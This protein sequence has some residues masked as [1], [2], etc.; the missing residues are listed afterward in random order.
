[1]GLLM[2]EGGD[3][4]LSSQAVQEFSHFSVQ[5]LTLRAVCPW[6]HA[7]MVARRDPDPRSVCVTVCPCEPASLRRRPSVTPSRRLG[8][9]PSVPASVRLSPPRVV[10]V[11]ASVCRPVRVAS[12]HPVEWP[13]RAVLS[14]PDRAVVSSPNRAVLSS[15]NRA[16]L[17]SPNRAV[18]SYP[19]RAKSCAMPAGLQS[20]ALGSFIFALRASCSMRS[21]CCSASC[22]ISRISWRIFLRV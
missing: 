16:V 19:N 2:F 7:R 11:Q 10:S 8:T 5:P 15:P 4:S 6:L 14:S 22:T 3:R 18:V 12:H 13:D 1:M 9:S 17:S 20:G 21:S